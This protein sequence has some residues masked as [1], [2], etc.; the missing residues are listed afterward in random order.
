MTPRGGIINS[1]D[2]DEIV[3]G[4][5]SS[6]GEDPSAFVQNNV[7]WFHM[8]SAIYVPQND[9]LI[10]SSRENFVLKLDYSAKKIMWIMGDTAKQW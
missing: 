2:F 5:I 4:E 9:S 7:D 8:N 10:V 1:W 6:T 3:G